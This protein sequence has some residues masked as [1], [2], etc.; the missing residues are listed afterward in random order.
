MTEGILGE[1]HDWKGTKKSSVLWERGREN[2][3]LGQMY[4]LRVAIMA[5]VDGTFVGL[6][7][8]LTIGR[9]NLKGLTMSFRVHCRCPLLRKGFLPQL[10]LLGLSRTNLWIS[11]IVYTS[12]LALN[13][14]FPFKVCIC[15]FSSPL[16][17]ELVENKNAVLL[18][19]VFLIMLSIFLMYSRCSVP[20][21]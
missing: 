11:L 3:V 19:F 16:C 10:R 14:N 18:T 8:Q 4:A 6:W 2:I 9:C 5:S 7:G 1:E 20:I 15:G 13:G 21:Y 12:I 17:W